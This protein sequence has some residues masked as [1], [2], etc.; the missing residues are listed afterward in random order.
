MSLGWRWGGAGDAELSEAV[1][2]RARARFFLQRRRWPG[3]CALHPAAAEPCE[4]LPGAEARKWILKHGQT[5]LTSLPLFFLGFSSSQ[6]WG[7]PSL[8]AHQVRGLI[9]FSSLISFWGSPTKSSLVAEG[10]SL[11][12]RCTEN[13]PCWWSNR[14]LATSQWLL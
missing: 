12:E 9:I 8:R 13:A 11:E 10:L 4:P 2:Q 1:G 14:P 5:Q 7:F 6:V 3:H